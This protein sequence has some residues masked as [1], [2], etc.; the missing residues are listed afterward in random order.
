MGAYVGLLYRLLPLKGLE[1]YGA[2]DSFVGLNG[3]KAH[4]AS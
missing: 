3:H 2:T 4:P 1:N